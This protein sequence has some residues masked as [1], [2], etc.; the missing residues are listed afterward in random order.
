MGSALGTRSRAVRVAARRSRTCRSGSPRPDRRFAADQGKTGRRSGW[1]HTRK[2]LPDRPLREVPPAQ[3]GRVGRRD[4]TMLHMSEVISA[5]GRR[6]EA[7]GRAHPRGGPHSDALRRAQ[8]LVELRT[9]G[10]TWAECARREGM[11]S[12]ANAQRCVVRAGLAIKESDEEKREKMRET[13][14][15]RMEHLF[16]LAEDMAEH[17]RNPAALASAVRVCERT[18]KMFGLD[19]PAEVSLHAPTEVELE[20]FV[21]NMISHRLEAFPREADIFEVIEGS[22][23]DEDESED[24]SEPLALG[25]A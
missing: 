1:G 23:V 5:D 13:W 20:Q 14:R 22:V 3:I 18:C 12:A 11:S 6:R 19:A 17:D 9:S 4:V 24:T 10:L 25:H 8:R 2:A 15:L 7:S 16:Q 21:R